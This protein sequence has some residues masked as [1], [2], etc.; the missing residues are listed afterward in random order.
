MANQPLGGFTT[1]V[2][3]EPV[4]ANTL[5]FQL[6][7]SSSGTKGPITNVTIVDQNGLVVAGPVDQNLNTGSS[8]KISFSDAVVFPVGTRTYTVKGKIPSTR[9]DFNAYFLVERVRDRR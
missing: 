9:L 1:T 3:G 4:V 7:T 8:N 6:A 5:N 2:Q